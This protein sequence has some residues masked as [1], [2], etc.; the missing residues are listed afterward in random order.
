[1]EDNYVL[2]EMLLFL[3]ETPSGCHNDRKKKQ[4]GN[5]LESCQAHQSIQNAESTVL[6]AFKYLVQVNS[7]FTFFRRV[8]NRPGTSIEQLLPAVL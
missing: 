2:H 7:P 4:I 5:V 8:A 6:T 1:M 3:A